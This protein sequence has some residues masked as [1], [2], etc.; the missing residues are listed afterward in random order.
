MDLDFWL[1]RWKNKEIGFHQDFFHPFLDHFGESFFWDLSFSNA[2]IFVPLC[3]KSLDLLWFYHRNHEVLGVEISSIA[4]E[5]FF[6]ENKI[7]YTIQSIGENYLYSSLDERIKIFNGDFFSLTED[8]FR[9]YVHKVLGIYDRASLVALPKNLR[10]KYVD[11]IKALTKPFRQVKYFLITMEFPEIDDSQ[12]TGPPFSVTQ[13]EIWESYQ[14]FF[15]IRKVFH[16]KIE[17][18]NLIPTNEV[19]YFLE[20]L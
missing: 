12:E 1:E 18:R 16:R 9:P 5:E 3:G 15:Q 20:R 17:R 6:S 14:S 13:E 8:F 19:L 11:K 4:C 7:P 2:L 10:K